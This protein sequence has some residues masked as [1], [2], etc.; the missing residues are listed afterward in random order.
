MKLFYKNK[1]TISV[2]LTIILVPVLLLGGMTTDAARIC[3]SKVVISDAGEMAMNAG[4]AQYNEELHDEYGL[5]VMDQSPEAMESELEEYFNGSLNGTGLSGAEDYDKILDLLTK[6]FDAINVLG[7]EIYQTEV[8]KQQILEYMKY[9][10]PVC[11]TELVIEKL[12]EMKNSK[13]MAEAMK[14]QMEFSEAMEDCQNEFKKAKEALDTL[15]GVINRL[16]SQAVGQELSQTKEEY[17]NIV[18]TALLMWAVADGYEGKLEKHEWGEMEDT[19]DQFLITTKNIDWSTPFADATFNGYVSGKYYMNT[20]DAMGG[21]GKLTE[22]DDQEQSSDHLEKL[23]NEYEKRAEKHEEYPELFLKYARMCIDKHSGKLHEYLESAGT[24]EDAA[25]TTCDRLQA[26]KKELKKAKDAF[27]GWEKANNEL[28]DAGNDTGS[29]DTDVKLYRDFF[30]SSNGNG[31]ADFEEL[32]SLISDTKQNQEYFHKLKSVLEGEKFW[33]QSIAIEPAFNQYEKYKREADSCISG[34]KV[35]FV[36]DINRIREREYIPNHY[37]H[38]DISE[39]GASKSISGHPFYKRIQEYCKESNKEDSQKEQDEANGRLEESK[40]AG[41]EAK[42]VDDYPTFKWSSIENLPSSKVGKD[43]SKA[44]DQ[45]T[46]LNASGDV[47]NSSARKE[48]T[49]KFQESMDAA[50]SFLDKVEEIVSKGLENLYISEYAMQ[51]FSYYTVNKKDGQN[52]PEGEIIGISGYKLSQHAAYQAECEYILWGKEESQTNVQNTVMMIF[53]IRLLFNSFFAFTDNEI[54]GAALAMATTIA[55]GWAP[56]LIP[57]IKVVIKLGFAGVETANDITKIKQGYGVVIVKKTDTWATV[58]YM[59]DN[60][61]KKYMTL[62]YS[63][64]LRV[65]LN[66]SY[67]AKKEAGI[68]GRIADCIQA[69]QPD[70]N[71]LEGYTMLSVQAEVS[72]RTTFMRKISDWSGSGAW[73]FPDD[74]YTI[75]YQSILGY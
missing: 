6:K 30:Y 50:V 17:E 41:E 68:L 69:N 47:N 55:G 37:E 32:D 34:K 48:T 57:I 10:A 40:N 20:I 74:T 9:R 31:K 38:K 12:K 13:K 43:A 64:Y 15:N 46:D 21:I 1:G 35:E 49:K 36:N 33:D 58:P 2:F 42:K 53:G 72:S 45:L 75:S 4:L 59:G 3:M 60:T 23:K 24:A 7:S 54:D 22:N 71:L 56:Y 51:M 25:K 26:V 67:L 61:K 5:L 11:L 14:K 39:A 65:F 63:E 16:D 19:V 18:S 27:D 52:R 44:G 28:K 70:M 62:D 66:I 73:G 29:M 8:E